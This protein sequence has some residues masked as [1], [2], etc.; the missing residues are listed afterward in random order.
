MIMCA[1]YL[2]HDEWDTQNQASNQYNGDN[3]NNKAMAV[4]MY[5]SHS[6]RIKTLPDFTLKLESMQN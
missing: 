1:V 6:Y 5:C 4:I 3:I 2:K